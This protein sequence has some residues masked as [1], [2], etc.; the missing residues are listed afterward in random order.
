MKGNF[1]NLLTGGIGTGTGGTTFMKSIGPGN[2]INPANGGNGVAQFSIPSPAGVPYTLACI[3]LSPFSYGASPV[4]ITTL[5]TGTSSQSINVT[6]GALRMTNGGTTHA[7][8]FGPAAGARPF[9]AAVTAPSGG[10]VAGV[11]TQLDTGTIQTGTVAN[12]IAHTAGTVINVG[13]NIAVNQSYNGWLAAVM[14]SN[15]LLSVSQL[16]AWAADPWSFWYP[17]DIEQLIDFSLPATFVPPPVFIL[18]PQIV[19]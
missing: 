3:A 2:Q 19:T 15:V 8:T 17:P 4:N 7:L 5:G 18:M 11:M 9:F 12:A 13:N 1:T 6:P 16:Q 14:V 10:T